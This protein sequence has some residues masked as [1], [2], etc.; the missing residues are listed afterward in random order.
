[1]LRA[2]TSSDYLA[3]TKNDAILLHSTGNKPKNGEVDVPIIYADY[4]YVEALIRLK[5]ILTIEPHQAIN[6]SIKQ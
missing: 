4:Y 3:G 1:M 6:Q 5:K 2:L